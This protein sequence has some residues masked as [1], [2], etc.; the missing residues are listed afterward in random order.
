M[1]ERFT[2]VWSKFD[3]KGTSAI[4]VAQ[5]EAFLFKLGA[6][7]GWTSKYKDNPRKREK[8]VQKLNLVK[9]NEFKNYRFLEVLEALTLRAFI[10]RQIEEKNMKAEKLGSAVNEENQKI[11]S[12]AQ[13]LRRQI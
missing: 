9:Y 7:L 2:D 4:P 1:A 5:F 8:Y 10:F 6:P 12:P 13:Y 11:I 3:P